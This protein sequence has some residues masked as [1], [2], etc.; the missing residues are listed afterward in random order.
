MIIRSTSPDVAIPEVPVTD[1]ILRHAERLAN[2]PALIDAPSGR[3][4]TY[5][6][7]ADGIKRVATALAQRGFR[8]G[9]VFAI[10]SPNLPEYAVVF[11]G[12]A[13][14]GGIVTTVN[15][16][17]TAGELANQLKD[18]KAKLLITVPPFLDKAKEAAAMAGGIEDIYVF[19]AAEG[20]RPFSELLQAPPAPPKVTIDP[21]NDVV[22]LPY[23]SGTTGLPK[24]VMLTHHNLVANLCQSAG[25]Q[26]FEAFTERDVVLAVLPY[27]HIYGMV[28]IMKLGLAGGGTV[29]SMPRF[30]MQEFLTYVQQ[31]K[32]T[33]LPLVPPIILGM[34]KH[35]ALSQF[36]LSSVRLVFSG[37]A[38]LGEELVKQL[39]V[40]LGCP[41]VQ[42][43]GMTEASP[44]THLSPTK[45]TVFKPGSCGRVVPNTEVKLVDPASGAELDG[46]NKEGELLMRGPQIMKGYLNRP[47]DTADSIDR[48]GWYH[49]GDVGYVDEDGWFFIVDRTKELI[50][51]KGM[52]VAP[53]ELEALLLT[54]PN[55]LDAAVVRK[56]DEE[57]GEVPKA[58]IVLK[59]DDASKTTKAE[60]ISAWVAERVAPHKRIRHIEFIDAIPK[61][62]SGK[63]LR[64]VLVDMEKQRGA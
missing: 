35:P 24:G 3:T 53:A 51:Y 57:A 22:V 20:A 36:D 49:T 10:Y 42:G 19:G 13:S 14:I 58:Y 41:V 18:S 1:Y 47:G 37:A 2:K 56:A 29:V 40:K 55:I 26:N 8:K 45:N 54:H 32:L 31:Y 44:V 50:K 52:Q 23:S 48:E 25:M 5:G 27:F 43:Y 63:I 4:L 21:K 15:P 61:S 6:Q 9:D 62:A 30:D 33:V 17:Y 59:A 39:S 12:V 34:V 11:H 60:A 64:R 7:L 28:V 16:L 46:P 38:P